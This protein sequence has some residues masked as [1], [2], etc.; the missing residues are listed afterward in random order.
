MTEVLTRAYS[1]IEVRAISDGRR[2]FSGIATTPTT[3]RVGD[4]ILPMGVRFANPLALLH[5][6]WHDR[7]IGSAVFGKPTGKGIAFDAEI[8]VIEEP[9]SLK[10]LKH[11]LIRFVSIGFRPLKHAYKDDGGIEYQEIEVIE[12]SIV[13]IPALPDAVITSVSKSMSGAPLSRDVIEHIRRF[14]PGASLPGAAVRL[15]Q[16]HKDTEPAL[17]GGAVRLVKPAS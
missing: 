7:P 6:H 10:E 9:P 1:A 8:P 13:T 4:T 2:T 11:K 15:V 16:L 3:D 17:P 12:L 14:D 5:Q